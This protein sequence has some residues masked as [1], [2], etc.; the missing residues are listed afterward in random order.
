M[1]S[2]R[3][4]PKCG[5]ELEA[6]SF[7]GLCV[8]CSLQQALQPVCPVEPSRS[9]PPAEKPGDTI[10]YYKLGEQLGEGGCGVVYLAEQEE[11]AAG[12]HAAEPE[13]VLIVTGVGQCPAR[14]VQTHPGGCSLEVVAE[15]ATPG[16]DFRP[17]FTHHH[18]VAHAVDHV[19]ELSGEHI[20]TAKDSGVG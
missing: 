14:R 3:I 16:E 13:V 2:K 10:G 9:L 19:A 1:S 12:V 15:A 8:P 18:C 4:C 7:A 5:D 20:A 6:D 11:P 17:A